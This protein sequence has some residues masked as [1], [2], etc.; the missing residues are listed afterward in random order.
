MI[1]DEGG[2]VEGG[3]KG[4]LDH[5]IV[6]AIGEGTREDKVGGGGNEGIQEK[7]EGSRDHYVS[8]VGL[9]NAYPPDARPKAHELIISAREDACLGCPTRQ[10]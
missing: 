2:E 5:H 3:G 6:G 8:S 4:E 1:V 10:H 7:K 9:V